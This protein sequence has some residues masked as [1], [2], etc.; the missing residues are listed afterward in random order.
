[1]PEFVEKVEPLIQENKIEEVKES[2]QK[3]QDAGIRVIMITGDQVSTAQAI[4]TELGISGEAVTGQELEAI[5]DLAKEIKRFGIFARV[6]PE[7]KLRIV[8]ALKKKGYVV[9]MTGDGVNDAP[10]L[11]KA[12][13]GI[14]MGITG[15]DVAKEAADMILTDDNFTSIVNAV[16]EGR[17]IFDNIRKFVNYLLSSNLGEIALILFA[18]LFGLLLPLTAIQILWINLITDGLPATAL[19]FDPHSKGIMQ[20]PPRPRRENILSRGS[21]AHIVTSGILIGTISLILFW[22]YLGSGVVKAQTMA[23]TSLVVFEIVRLQ[24][25]RAEYKL[26]L[27]SNKLLAGAVFFSLILHLGTLYTPLTTWFKTAPLSLVDWGMLIVASIVLLIVYKIV[28][29]I[30][31]KISKK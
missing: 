20:R 8:E 2:I 30:I 15:T 14:A 17:G 21:L 4:A 27:F 19:S 16:E 26:S 29:K 6:N 5:P 1:M 13:I 28:M 9:A 10:A 18:S 25:I 3:C 7:H 12:D 31:Q 11:K 24:T 22:L 23:F